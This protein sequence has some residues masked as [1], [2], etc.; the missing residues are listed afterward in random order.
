MVG[1]EL[2]PIV[3]VRGIFL[4][5]SLFAI[6][7]CHSKTGKISTS[8]DGAG[9]NPLVFALHYFGE[10]PDGQH[11]VGELVQ[12]VAPSLPNGCEIRAKRI[13]RRAGLICRKR[14]ARLC[15]CRKEKAF[16]TESRG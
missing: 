4:F 1:A 10:F 3:M 16:R 6:V 9:G 7:G 8:A 11:P 5:V 14:I 13:N 2:L 15:S 12:F